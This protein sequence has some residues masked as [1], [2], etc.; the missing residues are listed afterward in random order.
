MKY[1]VLIVDDEIK[2]REG[3][4]LL[5]ACEK[6][7]AIAGE[8]ANGLDAIT[9][10]NNI[11]PDIL[12]LDIQMPE[13][14]GFE[15]ICNLNRDAIPPV[16]IFIT[17]YDQYAVKAFAVHALDYLL[18]PFTNNRFYEALNYAREYLT[19]EK[20]NVFRI[21]LELL[22]SR[23]Q[24][25]VKREDKSTLVHTNLNDNGQSDRLIFKQSGKI[26]FL[27][28]KEICF[29][30]AKNNYVKI[31]RE[32]ENILL[33]ETIK[34][35][36]KRLAPHHFIRVQRSFIINI[37]YISKITPSVNGDYL[38]T[39]LNGEVIRGSRNYRDW[40]SGLNTSQT[41]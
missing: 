20:L 14:N 34:E 21:N 15:V 1:K 11:K 28:V 31:C 12:F 33:H 32:K 29:V 26:Y 13:V 10:I 41:F 37:K 9:Q 22:L 27:P 38:V 18:K 5:L 30:E 39:L 6:D 16:I 7:M 25:Q 3:I 8:C 4:R 36:E 40:L 17:A 19:G 2:A 24:Q 35:I 23:Y